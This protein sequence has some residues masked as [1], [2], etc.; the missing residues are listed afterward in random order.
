MNICLLTPTFLPKL[1]GVEIIVSSLA[2]QYVQAGHRVVVVTQW[3][4]KGRGTPEDHLFPYSVVR[5]KRPFSFVLPF[6][7]SSI[8]RSLDQAYKILPFDVIHCHLAYPTGPVAIDYAKKRAI[9]AVIT[10]HG[11]D[12][13]N[14][15][16]Y[17][18]RKFIWRKISDALKNAHAV[19]AISQE[20]KSLLDPI[21][22][23]NA[24]PV[25]IIPNAVDLA[26]LCKPVDHDPAWPIGKSDSFILY[27]GGL[28]HKKGVDHLIHAL[29]ILKDQNAPC[30]QLIVAGDGADRQKLNDLVTTCNLNDKIRFIGKV[31]GT[32]KNYLL[33]NCRYVVMP[34]LT[35]GFGLVAIEAFSCGKPL[36]AS[37]VGG[38]QELMGSHEE[39]GQLIPPGNPQ[40]LAQAIQTMESQYARY[41]STQIQSFARQFDWPNIAQAYIN[42]YQTCKLASSLNS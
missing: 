26:D 36:L 31:T 5:Y 24:K 40:A 8:K 42:L 30:P 23:K 21:L 18:E 28:T 32:F 27:L 39:L 14:D 9:P 15:S 16:R 41:D 12:I 35:E 7:L 33:Q 4:R 25:P 37:A 11:S 34:S 17:R 3:P 38:L 19:T 1:G 10:T 2:R 29:K 22:G 20:M 6:G 13:R